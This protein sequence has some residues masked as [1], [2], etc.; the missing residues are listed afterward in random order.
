M[1]STYTDDLS[2]NINGGLGLNRNIYVVNNSVALNDSSLTE[3]VIN[4][5][6]NI[7]MY[8]ISISTNAIDIFTFDTFTTNASL[9]RENGTSCNAT[10]CRILLYDA[11]LDVVTFNVSSF[12]SYTV[13]AEKDPPVVAALVPTN[14]TTFNITATIEIAANVTDN[15]VISAVV[16]N[17]SNTTGNTTLLTLS[18]AGGT[19]IYNNTYTI[20]NVTGV[21]NI[22]I[23]A[24]DTNANLN[25]NQTTQFNAV[26]QLPPNISAQSCTPSSITTENSTICN[27][28]I[29]DHT[30]VILVQANVTLPNGTIEAQAIN[31]NTNNFYF[32]FSNTQKQLLI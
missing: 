32:N 1:N 12:S 9:I 17:V 21:Y 24:N 18:Q 3:G 13:A 7:T 29:T 30:G 8:N 28:T 14:N 4:T 5:S 11:A 31:N 2:T 20:S 6:A 27:A 23:V 25:R 15:D 16:A 26:D 22:T 10:T 19:R